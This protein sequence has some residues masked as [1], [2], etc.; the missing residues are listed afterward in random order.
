M[1]SEPEHTTTTQKQTQQQVIDQEVHIS[2]PEP[3]RSVERVVCICLD[4]SSG[5]DAFEWAVNEFI[6]PDKD[7]VT[8]LHVRELDIPIT[9]YM[10]AAVYVE[11][12]GEERRE[13]SHQLLKHFAA[14]L[15]KK[16]VACKAISMVGDPKSEL[17]RKITEIKADVAIVGSRNYG[18]IK[19]VLLGSVSDH[20]A[21]H[22]PCTVI[23]AKP[24]KK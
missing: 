14:Q 3:N 17:V 10:T 24:P 20:L 15:V 4:D 12:M 7:M 16:N 9:P 11:E 23:I 22:C 13:E 8:L 1:A 5:K 21:H 6:Q 2:T 19:R 18:A